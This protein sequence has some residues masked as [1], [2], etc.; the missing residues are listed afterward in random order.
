MSIA[1]V[2]RTLA[3]TVVAGVLAATT[4]G[5]D[6]AKP[7]PHATHTSHAS[8]HTYSYAAPVVH[9]YR[10]DGLRMGLHCDTKD[11]STP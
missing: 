8:H 11:M 4:Y 5:A 1:R 9:Q 3:V 6:A 10:P 2:A 7:A